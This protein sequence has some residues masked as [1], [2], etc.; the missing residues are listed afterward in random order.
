MASDDPRRRSVDQA[1]ADQ[2]ARDAARNLAFR[3]GREAR[4]LQAGRGN[5]G[6]G[7]GNVRAVRLL[8]EVSASLGRRNSTAEL[9]ERIT[10]AVQSFRDGRGLSR[11]G[12]TNLLDEA[13]AA[14]RSGAPGPARSIL[15]TKASARAGAGRSG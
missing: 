8:Q 7:V 2:F 14:V 6:S 10:A 15:A 12:L 3:V 9:A 4:E 11:V 5:Y 1:R 13:T